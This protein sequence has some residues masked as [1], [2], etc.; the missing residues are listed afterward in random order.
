M[1]IFI[2]NLQS[3]GT[4]I[5]PTHRL[6]HDAPDFNQYRLLDKLR[7]RFELIPFTTREEG[8]AAL[9]REA[10]ALT[11]IEFPEDPQWVLVVDETPRARD[12][13][14]IPAGRLEDEIFRPI[15]GL[16]TEAIDAKQNLLYPHSLHELDEMKEAGS[17]D[18]AFILRSIKP[19][20][21]LEVVQKGGYMPQKS[22]YFYPKLLTGLV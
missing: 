14:S 21:M 2:S 4:I 3:D 22:T 6:L 18:A 7:E 1:M 11:L 19:D 16:S 15:V 20:E 13:Q 12:I 9:N 5:L 8:V 17:W 10:N